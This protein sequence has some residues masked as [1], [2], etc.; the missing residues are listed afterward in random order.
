MVA[1]RHA[2]MDKGEDHCD[3]LIALQ[4]PPVYTLGTGSLEEYLKFDAEDA[5]FEVF[6]TERGG[7]VTFHG[8]G[9]LVMYPILNL[10]RHKMDLHWYL[11]S[12]EE[13]I[14]R[15][16]SAA[17]SVEACRLDGLTG[18]WVGDQKIAAIGIR[19][20]RWLTYHGLALNVST[21]L[22]PFADIVPCGIRDRD[23]GSL[24]RLLGPRR[25]APRSATT[26]S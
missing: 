1:K 25:R 23:V 9:Q 3:A 18:V 14:I 13:V 4:H 7:E 19:V 6:R 12:L 22:A 2:L 21:D 5:P 15:A 20:S 10:R 8:P 26:F 11:R 24:H 16:L 17:F